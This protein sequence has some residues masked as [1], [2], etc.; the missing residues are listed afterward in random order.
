MIHLGKTFLL[1]LATAAVL[2]ACG[3]PA[4]PPPDAPTNGDDDAG[5]ATGPT[6]DATA[7]PDAPTEGAGS[8]GTA[9]DLVASKCVACHESPELGKLTKDE[10]NANLDTNHE[11]VELTPEERKSIVDYL[12][13]P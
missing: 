3:G 11:T 9:A 5:A 12:A 1:S 6:P 8:G 10:F 4:T 7:V 2:A 13:K